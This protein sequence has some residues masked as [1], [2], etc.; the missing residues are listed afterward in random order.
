MPGKINV[1]VVFGGRSGEHDISLLSAA[2]VMQALDPDK[3]HIIPIGITKEGRWL[4]GGDPLL[5]LKEQ[6]IPGDCSY[7]VLVTDPASPGILLPDKMEQSGDLQGPDADPAVPWWRIAEKLA[8]TGS[9][10]YFLPLDLVFPVLHG[11]FGED[12]TIQGLLELAG[13]PYVGAGVL[14]SATGMDKEF[15][16][17]LFRH[18][19][20]EIGDYIAFQ[21]WQ[22]E[23]DETNIV[24]E[25]EDRLGYPCFIK[26]ANMGSS[27]GISKASTREM[28][29]AGVREALRFDLKVV[30]EAN[31]EGREIECSVLGGEEEPLASVPGEIVP[32]NDFYD[33]KAKY[34]DDR[35][36]LL[37]PAPL[38]QDA[39]RQVQECAKEAFLAIAGSGLS[40]VDFFYQD[41]EKRLIVNEINTMPGFT[42]ISMYPKLWEAS[43]I[44]YRALIDKLIEIALKRYHMR[45]GLLVTPEHF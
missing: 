23:K 25:I 31:I 19:G 18:R 29:S 38:E 13:L 12:G 35:S 2:S 16:K 42:S 40:R 44:P 3:Y 5:A 41:K 8:K 15:M 45:K 7:A 21:H 4:A 14:S 27:V 11:P 22:W 33:Y 37:I 6:N 32:C 24:K 10:D 1:G 20:L 30:V 26:P 28:L 39:A 43:G 17:I 9:N 36:R 34:I